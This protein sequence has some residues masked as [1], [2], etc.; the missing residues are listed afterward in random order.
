MYKR[1]DNTS[2]IWGFYHTITNHAIYIR[3]GT[4]P[5]YTS[6]VSP[7]Q[8]RQETIEAAGDKGQLIKKV[9]NVKESKQCMARGVLKEPVEY[10]VS[11]SSPHLT[12]SI[13]TSLVSILLVH[14][15]MPP[16]CS[17][18]LVAVNDGHQVI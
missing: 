2:Y 18:V 1:H 7:K 10:G 13:K 14:T 4:T 17:N 11:M 9:T 3:R 12:V 6:H 16:I 5:L 8:R 15:C